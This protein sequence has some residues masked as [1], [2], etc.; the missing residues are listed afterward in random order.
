[1]K[2]KLKR[3]KNIK[4]IGLNTIN[5]LRKIFGLNLKKKSEF[6]TSYNSILRIKKF[7]RV[8]KTSSLLQILIKKRINNY[9]LIK[10]Y[11]G[12]RHKNGYPVHGQRTHTNAKTQ[13]KLA[14]SRQ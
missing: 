2:K 3:I 7:L 11:T 5:N 4:G 9:I 1:M 6:L 12:I 13:R 10:S 14:V 8:K